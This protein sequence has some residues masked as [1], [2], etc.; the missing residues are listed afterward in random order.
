MLPVISIDTMAL[1]EQFNLTMD[2]VD[3]MKEAV[4]KTATKVIH[5]A[6]R[7]QA[8]RSL[9]STRNQY[10]SSIIVGEVGRFANV[11]TLVGE[12]PN[13]IEQGRDPYDMKKGFEAS[14]KK[15]IT[16]NKDGQLGWYLTIPFTWAQPGSLGE[17]QKFTGVLPKDVAKALESKQKVQGQGASLNLGDIPAEFKIPKAR[18]PV[19]LLDSVMVPEYQNKHSVYE[20]LQQKTK[21]GPVMSFRRVSNNS[22]DNSWIHTGIKAHNLAEKAIQD[23]KIPEVVG[24]VIDAYLDNML[25]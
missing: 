15:V 14:S 9:G 20:G 3:E 10:M 1:S 19:K 4:V 11:I 24:D 12:L 6:W 13:M 16:R 5:T 2:H 21:G 25:G 17:S 7:D 8:K 23:A 18:P 22:D